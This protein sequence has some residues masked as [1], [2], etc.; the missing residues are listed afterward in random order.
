M[1]KAGFGRDSFKSK[2]VGKFEGVKV[3]ETNNIGLGFGENSGGVTLPPDK[4]LVG[5][6]AYSLLGKSAKIR[7]LFHHEFGH[8]LQ[9]RQSFVGLDGFY[10]II[11]PESFAS[12]ALGT[13]NFANNFWTETWA[14]NLS[15]DY[16]GVAFR[17][18]VKY[19]SASLS[20]FNLS[21]FLALKV[22]NILK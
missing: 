6:G 3:Y 5:K 9:S 4:I 14:N 22:I 7:D 20:N 13:S 10:N 15:E 19:P 17:D 18:I 11:A 16:F 2:Y 21:K 1:K 8:I 12:S